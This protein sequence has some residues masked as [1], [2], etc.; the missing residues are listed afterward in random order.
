MPHVTN[1]SEKNCES[2]S[3]YFIPICLPDRRLLQQHQT[4]TG[5]FMTFLVQDILSKL[6]NFS[7]FQRKVHF[8]QETIS[9]ITVFTKA[10]HWTL[11]SKSTVQF[12][13]SIHKS[14]RFNLLDLII[15]II[16]CKEYMQLSSSLR[17]FLQDLSIS[18]L[19]TNIL[20]KTLLSKATRLCYSLIGTPNF[21][22][23]Q[24]K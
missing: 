1:F 8:I 16:F 11:S 13:R 15:L 2:E 9:F 10:R 4:P 18:L 21:A 24:Y 17:S 20:L 7:H 5:K 23:I 14:L 19:G 12:Y 22:P 3:W 6:V